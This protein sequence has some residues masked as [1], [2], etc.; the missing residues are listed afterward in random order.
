MIYFFKNSTGNDSDPGTTSLKPFKTLAKLAAICIAG[1]IAVL[2]DDETWNETLA[3][4]SG[5]TV[6]RSGGGTA[7]P[8]IDRGGAAEACILTAKANITLDGLD[9]KGTHGLRLQTSANGHRIKNCDFQGSTN[10]GVTIDAA[11][12]GVDVVFTDCTAHG[13]TLSGVDVRGTIAIKWI[14]GDVYGHTAVA[15]GFGFQVRD[16][17]T[18]EYDGVSVRLNR[19][20]IRHATDGTCK[21]GRSK[22]YDN[23]LTQILHETTT[24]T[25]RSIIFACRVRGP[26]TP[27]ADLSALIQQK[28]SAALE[29]YGCTIDNANNGVANLV[30]YGVKSEGANTR[31]TCIGNHFTCFNDYRALYIAVNTV[32]ATGNIVECHHNAYDNFGGAA[33]TNL[34][35]GEIAS[36]TPYDYAVWPT[37]TDRSGRLIGVGSMYADLLTSSD[38]V[39]TQADAC[40]EPASPMR[41]AGPN[42]SAIYTRDHYGISYPP[43][44]AWDI[45]SARYVKA[46]GH[47]RSLLI[48]AD[49]ETLMELYGL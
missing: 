16:T 10:N 12:G 29:V 4:V 27:G 24:T 47:K 44:G 36:N 33:A 41:G 26:S 42:L 2:M 25:G 20:G 6:K 1:D 5:V 39:A 9:L 43:T 37:L 35:W 15:T 32:G 21:V 18:V 8:K 22:V 48:V 46:A 38:P 7:R 40:P 45:G 14:G 13:N 11:T 23:T 30:T 17:A 3:P 19:I 31:L 49:D 28:D 34:K